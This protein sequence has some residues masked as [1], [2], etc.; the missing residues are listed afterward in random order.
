MTEDTKRLTIT[1]PEAA[2]RLGVSRNHAY[3]AAKSGQIPTIKIGKRLLVPI[4]AFDR[5]LA[6]AGQGDK[7]A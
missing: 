5:M 1:V 3:E 7:A 6:G 2:K 4:V